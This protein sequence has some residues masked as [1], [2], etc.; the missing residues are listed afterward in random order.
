MVKINFEIA[1][2]TVVAASAIWAVAI[3]I[4]VTIIGVTVY[5][6]MTGA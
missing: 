6:V 3:I 5:N 1:D 2:D 4:T